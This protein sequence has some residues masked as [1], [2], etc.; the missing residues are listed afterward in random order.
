MKKLLKIHEDF[1]KIHE[2]IRLQKTDVIS[3]ALEIKL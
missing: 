3:L 2:E 1:L